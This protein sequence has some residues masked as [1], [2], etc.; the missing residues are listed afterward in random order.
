MEHLKLFAARLNIP[1][2]IRVCEEQQHWREL[3]FLYV[4]YDEY[5]NAAL[6]MMAHSPTA[7]EH[8][9]FKDVAVKVS[10]AEVY[11]KAVSFYLEQHPDLLVD[12]LKVRARPSGYGC[13]LKFA[14]TDV[15]IY[16]VASL[17]HP[18]IHTRA[19]ILPTAYKTLPGNSCRQ[20]EPV[21]HSLRRG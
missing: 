8:V 13:F 20:D 3:V 12:L 17:E 21:G 19:L 18:F 2:L 11:Y 16:S 9:Q 6:V 7:W 10:N 4:A 5:D 1:R 14:C 15:R